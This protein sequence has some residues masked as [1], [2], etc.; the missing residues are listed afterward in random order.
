[1]STRNP[2]PFC[3]F[4]FRIGPTIDIDGDEFRIGGPNP[5]DTVTFVSYRTGQHLPLSKDEFMTKVK[6]GAIAFG[7][8]STRRPGSTGSLLSALLNKTAQGATYFDHAAYRS[9]I[10]SA[11]LAVKPG[12][13]TKEVVD[14]LLARA[15]REYLDKQRYPKWLI[16]RSPPSRATAYRWLKSAEKSADAK[17]LVP[18]FNLRGTR[19][20]RSHPLIEAMI[21][22]LSDEFYFDAPEAQISGAAVSI[23]EEIKKKLAGS[24][25]LEGYPVPSTRTIRARIAAIGGERRLEHE[26]G[27]RAAHLAYK[28]VMSGPD[29]LY[30]MARWEID[31]TKIDVNVVDDSGTCVIGRVWLTCIIDHKTRMIAGYLLDSQAP[32]ASSV[33]AALR[34][35]MLPKTRAQLDALGIESEWPIAGVPTE[36]ATDRGKDFLSNSVMRA[37]QAFDID[38]AEMP[39]RTPQ[40]K[41]RIERFFGTLNTMLFHRLRGT[42]KS[43]T[44]AKGDRKPEEE[45]RLTFAELD[46]LIGRTICDLYHNKWHSALRCTPLQ[47]WDRLIKRHPVPHIKTGPEIAQA[48]MLSYEAV[49]TRSGIKIEGTRYNSAEV[50]RVRSHFHA[51]ARGNPIVHALLDPDDISRI[52]VRDPQNGAII[53]IPALDAPNLKGTSLRMHRLVMAAL[54]SRNLAAEPS[55]YGK[56]HAELMADVRRINRRKH[57][58]IRAKG[59]A[60]RTAS[61]AVERDVPTVIAASANLPK[62]Q[63]IRPIAE[64]PPVTLMPTLKKTTLDN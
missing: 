63:K 46:S 47:M 24:P 6:T 17:L 57:R 4:G 45:A 1:M 2:N 9:A 53:E 31:H 15:H 40:Y 39:P 29:L 33:L 23:Q 43:N 60:A 49:A 36:L 27:K 54:K 59:P 8:S 28:Q 42:T 56:L 16:D 5:D 32:S 34:F 52:H 18:A 20:G 35:A 19:G 3:A 62:I 51:H 38:L 7:P 50:S 48:T 26:E 11:L 41:G 10:V 61:S 64:Q 44:A 55:N 21:E 14:G 37:L 58:S 30:P 13:R 22:E 12:N 25:L